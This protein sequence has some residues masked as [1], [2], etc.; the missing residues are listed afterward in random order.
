MISV[1]EVKRKCRDDISKIENY[2]LA[3]ADTEHMWDCHHRLELTLDGEFAHDKEDLKRLGM[4]WHRPYYELIFLTK[5]EHKKI[6]CNTEEFKQKM[7][8][9]NSC[10]WKG[11]KL[12]EETKRKMS[13][14]SK[15]RIH[16]NFGEK[17]KEHF[18]ITCS[19]NLTLYRTEYSWYIRHN[20][21][22]SWEN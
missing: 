13:E 20:H 5:S 7:S 18:G 14:A 21:K 9:C 17:F 22:C 16:S 8:E 19:D 6:H 4:Y 15:G 3:I 10:Y 11:R 2:E 1:Q 12:S